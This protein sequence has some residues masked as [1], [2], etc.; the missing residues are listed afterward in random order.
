MKQQS[1][2]YDDPIYVA[3]PEKEKQAKTLH[4]MVSIIRLLGIAI[5]MLGIAIAL[6]RLAGI[7]AAVGYILVVIGLVQT[8]VVPLKMVRSFVK[9]Q[10][11]E[12]AR[13]SQEL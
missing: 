9:R 12:D 5:L 8:W 6:G 11:A 10:V 13:K 2:K 1:E 7:P 3:D 4:Y